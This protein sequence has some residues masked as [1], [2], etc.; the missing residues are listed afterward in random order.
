[1]NY[2]ASLPEI[3][4][5]DPVRCHVFGLVYSLELPDCSIGAGFI[6]NAVWDHLHGTLTSCLAGDVDVIW[7]DPTRADKSDDL[8]IEAVL[9]NS[10]PSINWSVKNQVRMHLRNGDAPY[11]SAV[12]A[13]R[14][15]PETATAVAARQAADGS[16][17]IAAPF[18]LDDL[19]TLTLRPTPIFRG[20]KHKVYL[21]RVQA[22][23]WLKTWPR[24]RMAS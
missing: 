16:Y 6:R 2:A 20:E 5:T 17:E 14:G 11:I 1:M 13:M 18:G 12:D 24:L 10:D 23:G 21:N 3:L 19:F 9:R 15:W 22:K 4:S 8:R 7:F